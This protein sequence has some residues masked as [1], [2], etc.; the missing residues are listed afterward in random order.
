MHSSAGSRAVETWIRPVKNMTL[1][2]KTC[3]EIKPETTVN[4]GT[5]LMPYVPRGAAAW[6]LPTFIIYI[7]Y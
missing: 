7:L 5:L 6:I 2:G 4:G 1:A 3:D